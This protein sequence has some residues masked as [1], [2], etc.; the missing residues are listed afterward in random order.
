MTT[1]SLRI[2]GMHCID[3]A[4]KVEAALKT[5]SGV[6]DAQVHYL[7]RRAQVTLITDSADPAA[8]IAAVQAAGYDASVG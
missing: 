7:K 2:T 3:C 1:Q 5:V 4:H 8:L 6:A